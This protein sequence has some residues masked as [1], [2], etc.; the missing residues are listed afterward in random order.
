MLTPCKFAVIYYRRDPLASPFNFAVVY[1]RRDPL[2]SL[3]NLAVIYYRRDPL[4][5]PLLIRC[6]L[7]QER[8]VG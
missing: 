1:Y 7:L 3:F 4:A 8:P 5:N 2:A 6:N